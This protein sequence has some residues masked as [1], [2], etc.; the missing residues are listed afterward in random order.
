MV[1]V[2]TGTAV[3]LTALPAPSLPTTSSSN[4][5]SKQSKRSRIQKLLAEA[6]A[7]SKEHYGLNKVLTKVVD[8]EGV[9][10]SQ[11]DSEDSDEDTND[12]DL[13]AGN[14]DT[15]VLEVNCCLGHDDCYYVVLIG[16]VFP[17]VCQIDEA[18]DVDV[19]ELL[20]DP[21]PPVGFDVVTTETVP[22]LPID[23][24]RCRSQIQAFNRVWKGKFPAS[25]P[26]RHFNR[27]F[28]MILRV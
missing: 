15:C 12:L 9:K 14:K 7:S 4:I 25:H 13:S 5:S 11:T 23:D 10:E 2:A 3:F 8:V 19:I 1:G 17:F 27:C 26:M 18:E 22:G 28:E 21:E 16:F 6:H 24:H 20:I